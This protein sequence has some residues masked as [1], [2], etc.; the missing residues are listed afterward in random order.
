MGKLPKFIGPLVAAL[1]LFVSDASSQEFTDARGP[2][3]GQTPPG[4]T[5][6]LFASGIVSTDQRELNSVFTPDGREFYFAYSKGGG[7][8]TTMVMRRLG[9]RWTS[10]EVASFSRDYSNVDVAISHDGKR[11]FFGS[12]RPRSGTT[13]RTNGFDLWVAE[14]SGADWGPPRN[15]GSTVNSDG[16][17]I[18]PTVTRDGTL[19]FQSNRPGGFGGTDVYRAPIVDGVYQAPENLGHAINT[20]EDEGDV[21]VAPDESWII[22]SAQGRDDSLGRGDLYISFRRA[23]G[24]FRPAVNMGAPINS[25]SIDFCPM[26]SPDGKYL[27]FSSGRNGTPD[28]FWVDA[29]VIEAF[30]P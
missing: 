26:L 9:E 14:R 7:D 5:P 24:S 22:V 28:I 30:K 6:A 25:A 19:Y 18:Y 3:L 16:H 10:P 17:Q 23:D 12:N 20:A 1:V 4:S 13:P 27:F 21:L 8:Y 11:V 29:R 2:Y 15:L